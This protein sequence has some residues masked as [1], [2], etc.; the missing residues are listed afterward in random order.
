MQPINNTF[1]DIEDL[2]ERIARLNRLIHTHESQP[3][4]ARPEPDKL[5]IE[6]YQRLRQQFADEL[7]TMMRDSYELSVSVAA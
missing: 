3:N 7:S 2:L 6:G 1:E 4:A 5:T